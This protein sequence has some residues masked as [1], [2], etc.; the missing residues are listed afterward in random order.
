MQILQAVHFDIIDVIERLASSKPGS[1]C[2]VIGYA[3]MD[4]LTADGIRFTHS[5]LSLRG[6][7]DE[8]DFIVLDHV[9]DMR[10]PLTDLVYPTAGDSG[11]LERQS[12]PMCGQ[13]LEA[14]L[15]EL[16]RKH[17]RTRLIPVANADEAYPLARQRHARCSLGL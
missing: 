11:V 4:R 14:P 15:D 10:P 17:H 8:V 9:H 13:Y 3:P 6:V 16:P 2:R 1:Q 5:V 7:D 12:R